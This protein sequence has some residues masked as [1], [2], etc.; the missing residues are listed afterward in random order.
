VWECLA[1][2]GYQFSGCQGQQH[3]RGQNEYFKLEEYVLLS[4]I[5]ELLIQR[6]EYSIS[7]CG[8]LEAHNYCKVVQLWLLAADVKQFSNNAS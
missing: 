7:K 5:I 1:S 6:T 3:L 2:E 4:K 8:S